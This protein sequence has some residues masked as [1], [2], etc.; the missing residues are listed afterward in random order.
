[1]EISVISGRK[2]SFIKLTT[3]CIARFW[4][5]LFQQVCVF[6]TVAEPIGFVRRLPVQCTWLYSTRL[7]FTIQA[8]PPL[9]LFPQAPQASL[10]QDFCICC[11]VFLEFYSF[12]YSQACSLKTPPPTFAQVGFPNQILLEFVFLK[13]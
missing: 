13:L 2:K 7:P 6:K 8:R 9:F 3:N 4:Y 5:L 12:R 1:M 11:F 10:P